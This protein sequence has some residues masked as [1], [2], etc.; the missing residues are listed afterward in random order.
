MRSLNAGARLRLPYALPWRAPTQNR[1]QK[2][3]RK[4][5]YISQNRQACLNFN[6]PPSKIAS[7]EKPVACTSGCVAYRA[8][9]IRCSKSGLH[10]DGQRPYREM[11]L[12]GTLRQVPLFVYGQDLR[13]VLLPIKVATSFWLG[14]KYTELT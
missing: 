2:K 5:P 1:A 14:Q 9:R 4:K 8:S 11:L 7:D 6:S 13:S 3:F 12:H 10:K